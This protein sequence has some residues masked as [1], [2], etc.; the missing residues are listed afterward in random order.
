MGMGK[1]YN[2]IINCSIENAAKI[3]CVVP[4]DHLIVSSVSNWGAYALSAAVAVLYAWHIKELRL[5]GEL[6]DM[7]NTLLPT[8]EE[9][10]DKCRRIV[11]AGARDG[12]TGKLD[13][14]VDGMPMQDS[15]YVLAALRDI[16]T[17]LA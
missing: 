3:A 7:V 12:V 15:I 9:E 11:A 2:A 1:N 10:L 17:L 6:E 5:L 4:T 16:Q 8:N 14:F 13:L